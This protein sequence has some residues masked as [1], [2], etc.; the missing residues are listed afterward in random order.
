MCLRGLVH[1]IR[2]VLKCMFIVLSSKMM[3]LFD[4]GVLET[5]L[6]NVYPT[7]WPKEDEGPSEGHRKVIFTT[8]QIY[9]DEP[10]MLPIRMPG[11]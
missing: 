6:K 2:V 4:S 1:V 10:P 5:D 11:G 7:K 9:L 8:S 3:W